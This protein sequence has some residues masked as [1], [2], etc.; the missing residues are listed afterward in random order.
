MRS[1]QDALSDKMVDENSTIKDTVEPRIVIVIDD[2]PTIRTAMSI[3]LS[4]AGLMA[5]GAD[6]GVSGLAAIAEH[7][8]TLIFLDIVLQ[9]LNGYQLCQIIKQHPGSRSTPVIMLSGRDGVFDKI[10]G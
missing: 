7:R 4:R 6:S 5:V 9:R 8:P 2:S 1:S 3:T 10:R